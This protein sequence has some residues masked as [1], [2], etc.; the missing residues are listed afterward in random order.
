[1]V[2]DRKAKDQALN[3]REGEGYEILRQDYPVEIPG[4]PLTL[5][6][7]EEKGPTTPS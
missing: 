6:I 7:K 4:V 5:G 2:P 1:M 3:Q